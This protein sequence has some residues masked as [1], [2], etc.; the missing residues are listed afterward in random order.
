MG[1][2]KRRQTSAALLQL[3][4]KTSAPLTDESLMNTSTKSAGTKDGVA[5]E[6]CLFMCMSPLFIILL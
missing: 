2:P 5:Q 6:V 4:M 3:S 1:R